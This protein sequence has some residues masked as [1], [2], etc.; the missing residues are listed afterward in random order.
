MS[1]QV[2]AAPP[3]AARQPTPVPLP[4]EPASVAVLRLAGFPFR[5]LD[6]LAEPAVTAAAD[7]RRRAAERLE[8]LAARAGD[9][10]LRAAVANAADRGVLRALHRRRPYTSRTE[11]PSAPFAALLPRLEATLDEHTAAE[12][13][14]HDAYTA[15]CQATGAAVIERFRA[16]PAL[17]DMLLVSNEDAHPRFMSW[18][19]KFD[20]TR[21]LTKS[22]R[23]NLATLVRYLQRV[24]G[25]NDTTSHFGPL[26]TARLDPARTG[27][28]WAPTGL[29][30]HTMLSR[31]AADAIA[32]S[33]FDDLEVRQRLR[34]RQ[35][36]GAHRDGRTV[37]VAVLDQHL[38]LTDVQ[39][40]TRVRQPVELSDAELAVFARCDG[41][42]DVAAMSAALAPVD[43][44]ATLQQLA[45]KGAV[46]VRPELPYGA[47]DAIGALRDLIAGLRAGHPAQALCD[48]LR[49]AVTTLQDSP[50]AERPA[51]LTA[52]KRTFT[53]ATGQPPVRAM[54]GF[55][56]DRSV[57]H[58]HCRCLPDGL[59]VGAPVVARMSGE[60]ALLY[61]MFLLRPRWRLRLQHTALAGWFAG[62]FGSGPVPVPRYLS[63]FLADLGTLG[64]RFEEIERRVARIGAAME[65]ALLPPHDAGHHVH[66]VDRGT[67]ED[68]V[69]RHGIAEPA[70]CNPDLMVAARSR[71]DLA[72]GRLRLVIGDL[73]AMDDHLSHGSIAPF[74]E[75]AFPDYRDEVLRRYHTLLAPGEQ[76]ADVTQHHLNKTFPRIELDCVDIEAHDRSP[77]PA[78]A[79]LRLGELTVA[80]DGD[81]LRLLAPGGGALRLVVPPHAW[82]MLR[83]NPFA[84]F[85]FPTDTDGAAVEGAGR[86]HLPRIEVGD[87]VLQR[88]LWRVPAAPL[89]A[90]D[91][92][93][94]P[95]AF[96][97]VQRMRAAVGLPRHV[98]LRCPGEPKP[99]YCDLDA[100]LL[101][102]Q[103]TRMAGGLPADATI[104]VSE[105][106]PTPDELW[107]DDGNG[108][109]TSEIRYAVFA[110]P[111]P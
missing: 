42:T 16:T 97:Q 7:R 11:Q 60:L 27:V 102:R 98:F 48:A 49:A 94:E 68:L 61:D 13:A 52:L 110:A 28:D 38:I 74:V 111:A 4:W 33:I 47:E 55:Y 64:P 17:R 22:D 69:R 24:C 15:A 44:W 63:A 89:A 39:A 86:T 79:R 107:L 2:P 1:I 12:T 85:G 21:A 78:G 101:V 95:G 77:R 80:H 20:P 66:R 36:P 29:R 96:E 14:L 37:E 30:R 109:R 76:L 105:M 34:P 51:A 87:V 83:M 92:A 32:E 50:A 35:A 40:A 19:D 65:S 72:A 3:T 82:P 31:W 59:T 25:K 93:A 108:G 67:V 70:I 43:V 88:E 106:L 103:L 73:H 81:R 45:D 99:I 18:L 57:F 100:P 41:D 71:A 10:V 8:E 75:Q 62:R 46:H 84:V 5:W 91:L 23:N 9:P 26:A 90:K 6:D 58:E 56:S 53:E 54:S 104:T